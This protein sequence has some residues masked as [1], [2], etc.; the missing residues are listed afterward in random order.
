MSLTISL[1]QAAVAFLLLNSVVTA[2]LHDASYDEVA[3]RSD[4]EDKRSL[5]DYIETIIKRTDS[6]GSPSSEGTANAAAIDVAGKDKP[7]RYSR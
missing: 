4:S 5:H 2:Q 6:L 3:R 7:R 1:R